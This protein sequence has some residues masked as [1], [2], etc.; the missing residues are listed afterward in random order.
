M[1]KDFLLPPV[2]DT[3]AEVAVVAWHKAIG[4]QV[5]AGEV[6]FEVMTEKVNVEVESD[7]DGKLLE[8]LHPADSEV[9]V[10]AVVARYET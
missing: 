8:I 10:G 7:F 3:G 9:Q 2:T 5:K 4:D 6:L 1:I